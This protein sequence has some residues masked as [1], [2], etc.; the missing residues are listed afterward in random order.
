MLKLFKHNWKKGQVLFYSLFALT[1]LSFSFLYFCLIRDGWYGEYTFLGSI[2]IASTV[3]QVLM[4]VAIYNLNGSLKAISR[5]MLPVKPL[6]EYLAQIA[7]LTIYSASIGVLCVV[8][9]LIMKNY[10]YYKEVQQVIDQINMTT[11]TIS[12]VVGIIVYSI[13]NAIMYCFALVIARLNRSNLKILVFIG[14][15]IGISLVY[16][17]IPSIINGD[18]NVTQQGWIRIETFE[19]A[20]VTI[21]YFKISWSLLFELI[22]G[23]VLAYISVYIIKH[24]LEVH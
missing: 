20:Q 7:V 1:V 22:F 2:G 15:F 12:V 11:A 18:P 14:V 23:I 9:F 6:H 21:N 24:K 5:R 19:D 8:F 4:I 13:L 10:I 16:N 3:L 17:I